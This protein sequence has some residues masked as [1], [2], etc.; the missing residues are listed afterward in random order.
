MDDIDASVW[1]KFV[2]VTQNAESAKEAERFWNERDPNHAGRQW[3]EAYEGKVRAL[4]ELHNF[5]AANAAAM[6][7]YVNQ[8]S[9]ELTEARAEL[10][11][12]I[13]PTQEPERVQPG[14]IREAIEVE[15]AAREAFETEPGEASVELLEAFERAR[16]AR[17]ALGISDDMVPV[18]E[19][20]Q[21]YNV[22]RGIER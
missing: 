5:T 19:L 11:Q 16:D 14:E 4:N 10:G 7:K 8:L 9:N 22:D 20:D 15:V 12:E 21:D 2:E 3:F 17:L 13:D 18:P 6:V 1:G